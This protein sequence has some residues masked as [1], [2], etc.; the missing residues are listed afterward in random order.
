M[1]LGNREESNETKKQVWQSYKTMKEIY[2]IFYT[3]NV[4]IFQQEATLCSFLLPANGSRNMQK[5]VGPFEGNQ[6]TAQSRFL[7]EYFDI[8]SRCTDP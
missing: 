5:H 3:L 6:K 7:L 2:L 8:D 4:K 1:A